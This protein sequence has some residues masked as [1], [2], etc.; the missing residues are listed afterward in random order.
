MIYLVECCL[1]LVG[2]EAVENLLAQG[3]GREPRC[4]RQTGSILKGSESRG[5]FQQT[6]SVSLST[7]IQV[8]TVTLNHAQ[9]SILVILRGLS[10]SEENF[11][12]FESG[13][14]KKLASTSSNAQRTIPLDLHMLS[15]RVSHNG[16]TTFKTIKKT[17]KNI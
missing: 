8:H 14:S 4:S 17:F 15:C 1:V 2:T 12:M 13:S 7:F 5:K 9:Y 16:K 6:H 11:R 3:A 10:S